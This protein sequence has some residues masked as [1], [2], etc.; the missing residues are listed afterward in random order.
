M[1]RLRWANGV[2]VR[3]MHNNHRDDLMETRAGPEPANGL[4]SK[5]NTKKRPDLHHGAG[6]TTPSTT[7][8][9]IRHRRG[10]RATAVGC[11]QGWR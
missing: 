2:V 10:S 1:D 8:T 4:L 6:M 9:S 3:G 7:T 11:F 5:I